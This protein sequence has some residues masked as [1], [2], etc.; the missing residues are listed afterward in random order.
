MGKRRRVLL[1]VECPAAYCVQAVTLS[2]PWGVSEYPVGDEQ[3]DVQV[4]LATSEDIASLH[5]EGE[6]GNG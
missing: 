1:I 3:I 5:A 6:K 4:Y 2:H